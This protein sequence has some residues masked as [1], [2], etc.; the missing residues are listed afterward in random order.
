MSE[1]GSS[2]GIQVSA[3]AAGAG[4]EPTAGQLL[5]RA[6]EA[7][8]LHI[9][10][11]AVALKVPVKKLE[12]LEADRF[13]L[14]SDLVFARALAG[15]F[16]RILKVDPAPVLAKFP[17]ADGPRLRTDEAGINEPFK[18]DR[19]VGTGFR[20]GELARKPLAVA[21]VLLIIATLLLILLPRQALFGGQQSDAR[22]ASPTS[23]V[24]QT[25]VSPGGA[26]PAATQPGPMPASAQ[27]P[28]SGGLAQDRVATDVVQMQL[29]ARGASWVEVVDASGV[30]QL[31]RVVS[32]AEK[33]T[34]SGKLPL[35]VVLGKAEN[36]EVM[37]RGQVVDVTAS[38]RDSVARFE[39]K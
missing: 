34:V 5:R 12:A 19:G 4:A 14:L 38:T 28:A 21:I 18:G 35:A 10:A 33:V 26:A 37:V 23:A 11:L 24:V 9:A 6:R 30:V 17:P 31:R 32:A 20:W 2:S 13:D 3:D 36:I 1:V 27:P 25:L 22:L 15:S 16:C 7:E 8:G 39:V 29:N